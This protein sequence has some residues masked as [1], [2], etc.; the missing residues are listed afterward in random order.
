MGRLNEF[1]PPR[2]ENF[3]RNS[4]TDSDE[5]Q[6]EVRDSIQEYIKKAERKEKL[7]NFVQSLKTK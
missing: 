3:I 1:I 6:E 7:L 5:D 4:F 2:A